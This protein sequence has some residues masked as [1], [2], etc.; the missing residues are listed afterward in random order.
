MPGLIFFRRNTEQV[1]LHGDHGQHIT[2]VCTERVEGEIM[3]IGSS[4]AGR[5]SMG[6]PAHNSSGTIA[7]EQQVDTYITSSDGGQGIF[8]RRIQ[9]IPR[10]SRS[11]RSSKSD[12]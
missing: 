8:L 10:L 11:D 3:M 4:S 2:Q 12:G 6:N 9:H 5:S 1:V 7:G